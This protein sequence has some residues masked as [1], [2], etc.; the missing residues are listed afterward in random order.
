[1]NGKIFVLNFV[2]QFNVQLKINS[3]KSQ[4]KKND[5]HKNMPALLLDF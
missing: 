2:H 5:F 3:A 1:M 4:V